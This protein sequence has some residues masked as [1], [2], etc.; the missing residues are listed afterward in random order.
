MQHYRRAGWLLCGS[1]CC[2]AASLVSLQDPDQVLREAGIEVSSGAAAGYVPDE[3]CASCHAGIAASYADVGLARAFSRPRAQG[4][5]EDFQANRFYHA[6]SRERYEMVWSG[7]RLTF[8]RFQLDREGRPINV[9]ETGVDWILGSGH[10]ARTYLYRTPSGELF[11]LPLA[12]YSQSQR[13]GMAPG[14]DNPRHQGIGRRV[15]REC[16]FCHNAY[17]AQSAEIN[18]YRVEQTFPEQLPEGIGCQRCH[19]PGAAHVALAINGG[20]EQDG[21]ATAIVNPRKLETRL[22]R[23]VCHQCHLQPSVALAGVRRFGRGD[24]SYRPGEPLDDYLVSFDSRE[25]GRPRAERFEI[26]HHPYRLEQ[27]PCFL[28]SQGRLECLDCHDPHARPPLEARMRRY[29]RVCLSCHLQEE[30][31]AR[32]GGHPPRVG[33]E[34]VDCHMPQRRTQDVVQVVMTDHRI[35]LP[36]AGRDLQAPLEETVP[37]LTGLDFLDPDRAPAGRLGDAYAALAVLRAGPSPAA[38]AQ[39]RETLRVLPLPGWEPF[40]ELARYQI[41][42]RLFPEARA[43]IGEVLTREPAIRLAKEWMALCEAGTGNGSEAGAILEG[44]IREGP[45]GPDTYLYLGRL[46]L[47]RGDPA[48]AAEALLEAVRLRPNQADSWFLLGQAQV[49][50]RKFQDAAA[51]FRRALEVQPSHTLAYVWLA[52]TLLVSNRPEEARRYLL[53]GSEFAEDPEAVRAESTRLEVRP[54]SR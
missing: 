2:L 40:L 3:E 51:S 28:Q 27:S 9:W 18:E 33:A 24:Y 22:R 45:P 29:R 48:A 16:L 10:R 17:P 41:S 50:L 14:F 5:I 46:H 6:A 26:N 19:G 30:L 1:L 15:R 36:A 42:N 38:A 35:Q 20:L 31:T 39:L 49:R 7:E 11:Q 8:R 4:R 53:H 37:T 25:E 34:C 43:T 13:W 32:H 54:A 12:W 47:S 52:R 21:A 23:D 44:L